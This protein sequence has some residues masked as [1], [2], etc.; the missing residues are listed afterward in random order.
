MPKTVGPS[1]ANV[2]QNLRDVD[3]VNSKLQ[4]V[5]VTPNNI[6]D[7]STQKMNLDSF[8]NK[9]N[10]TS[11]TTQN[12]LNEVMK[13]EKNIDAKEAVQEES[14]EVVT[15]SAS[16]IMDK[17]SMKSV[18]NLAKFA[19]TDITNVDLTQNTSDTTV[20][21]ETSA[22]NRV[23]FDTVEDLKAI[24]EENADDPEFINVLVKDTPV[25]EQTFVKD[26]VQRFYEPERD[27]ADKS[28]IA[29]EIFKAMHGRGQGEESVSAEY[30]K[31]SVQALIKEANIKIQ[32][33]AK[34]ICA[35]KNVKKAQS[36]NLK[37]Q[38]QFHGFGRFDFLN[39]GPGEKRVLPHSNT[40]LVGNDWHVWI[41]G[42]D[43]NFIFDDHAV[44]FDTF[45]RGNIMDKYSRPY[46]N[47]KGEY[48]GGYINKRFEVDR[49]IPEGNNLQLLPGQL[50]RPY[51]P[52][53]ATFEARLT[54]AREKHAKDRGYEPTETEYEPT[55]L[56]NWKKASVK[57]K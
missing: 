26:A 39:Y 56:Y 51:L 6:D 50:R 44:D 16:N 24:M 57:K 42:K 5:N 48:V 15:K 8:R 31:A 19:Q 18:F 55:N 1:A 25:D 13:N 33:F 49:N 38:A 3:S 7:K 22:T 37:K 11:V 40:G 17:K 43:H 32:Q 27:E 23:E 35:Q 53:F 20:L 10:N 45:W 4:N 29:A 28:I 54:A 2:L 30:T 52:E 12:K 14:T 34:N 21:N 36:Y 41:R 9:L 46:R 47:E